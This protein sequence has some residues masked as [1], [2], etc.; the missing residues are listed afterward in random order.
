MGGKLK[1]F[2]LLLFISLST[3]T[4]GQSIKKIIDDAWVYVGTFDNYK[5]SQNI[6]LVKS[7]NASS[8]CVVSFEK[9]LYSFS[10]ESAKER[11]KGTWKTNRKGNMTLL[12]I[13]VDDVQTET[14]KVLSANEAT[15]KL[16]RVSLY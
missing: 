1:T 13:T 16:R 8:I 7:W 6:K 4:S 10:D 5:E 2:L 11:A 15:V 14:F 12:I 9:G 3:T